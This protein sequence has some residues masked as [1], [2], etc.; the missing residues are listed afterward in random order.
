[1]KADIHPEYRTVVF[2]DLSANAYFKVGSTIKTERTIDHDGETLPY[3]TIDVSSASH[4]YYTGKQKEFSK[5][6][7]T[8]RF[9]QRFGRFIGSK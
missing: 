2:H 3:V 8:A 1:M 5:E 9:Q 6:G 4:P 7:S